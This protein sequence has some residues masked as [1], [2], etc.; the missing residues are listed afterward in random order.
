MKMATELETFVQ[1]FHQLWNSGLNAHLDLDTRDGNAWVSL[2]V[3][4]GCAP[5][6]LHA[7]T[8]QPLAKHV[9]KVTSPSRQRRRERRAAAA[10]SNLMLRSMLL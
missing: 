2:H 4:L 10:A 5:G 1:K 7:Q 3:Q 6:P 9:V 8:D